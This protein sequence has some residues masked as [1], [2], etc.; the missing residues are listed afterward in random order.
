MK[1]IALTTVVLSLALFLVSGL[2]QEKKQTGTERQEHMMME[3]MKDSSMVSMM[4]DHIAS[5]RHLRMMMMEKM[6]RYAN[7][8]SSCM[9][10][11]CAKMM[12]GKKNNES[13]MKMSKGMMDHKM[14]NC[15]QMQHES[16]DTIKIKPEMHHDKKN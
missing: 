11:M 14:M 9:M 3:M 1:K 15:C 12:K 8:D 2:A 13:M 7:Q 10:E 5:D 4:M 16:S 6:M